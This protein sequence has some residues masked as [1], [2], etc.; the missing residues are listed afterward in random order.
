MSL[1]SHVRKRINKSSTNIHSSEFIDYKRVHVKGGKGGDGMICF[2]QLWSNPQAGPSGGD[3]GNG[4][5]VIFEASKNTK[6]LN[7][8]KSKYTG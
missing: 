5:H 1:I 7:Q 3:G 8:I 2:L 4:G 6:S